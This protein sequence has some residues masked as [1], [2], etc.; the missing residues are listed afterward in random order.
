MKAYE[1]FNV[2]VVKF[3]AQDVI[4]ASVA[5]PVKCTCPTID[6]MLELQREN[7]NINYYYCEENKHPDCKAETHHCPSNI[8]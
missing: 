3:E 4:T 6:E 1:R 2:E 8:G 5:A 7:P